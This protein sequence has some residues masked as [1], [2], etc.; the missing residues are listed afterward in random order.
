MTSER[1]AWWADYVA[2]GGCWVSAG[3]GRNAGW[4]S[5]LSNVDQ[6]AAT[7]AIV[8][9]ALVAAGR[10]SNFETHTLLT[11]FTACQKLQLSTF[12]KE[13]CSIN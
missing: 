3:S 5:H 1:Q 10:C 12:I 4:L 2:C 6:D 11:P 9:G 8:W 13:T 7:I